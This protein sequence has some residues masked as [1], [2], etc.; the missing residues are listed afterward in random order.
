MSRRSLAS[1]IRAAEVHQAAA[2]A[3]GSFFEIQWHMVSILSGEACE[4]PCGWMAAPASA[5]PASSSSCTDHSSR[6]IAFIMPHP[7]SNITPQQTNIYCALPARSSCAG[8]LPESYPVEFVQYR[9]EVVGDLCLHLGT[10]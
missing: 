5:L 1:I 9:C 4:S 8:C 2:V 6:S 7:D 10:L 3:D